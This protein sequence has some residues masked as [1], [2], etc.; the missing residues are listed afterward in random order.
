MS[1]ELVQKLGYQFRDTNHLKVALTHRSRG[2]EHN[3]RLEF[4]GDAVV[5][6]VIAEILY[7]Q[8]PK[9][10]EGDLSR[11]RATLVNRDALA[12]VARQFELGKYIFLGPGETRSGGSERQS[13]LSCA[14][15]AVIGAVYMD[16][17]FD[18]VRDRII[19]WYKDMLKSLS[20][21]SSHKDPKTQLQEFLQSQKLPLPVYAV[22]AIEGQAH[23]QQF[24]VCCQ[25]DGVVTKTYGKGTSRRRAEQDAA[26][27]ML[28][29]LKK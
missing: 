27:A 23:Q 16:G 15:E 9:A 3:E 29:E 22:T 26:M 18:A 14:M 28:G 11:W 17:G 2:G 12:D 13:I 10:S 25:I 6:F 4:L 21:A 7:Q 20:S 19:V 5:N 1:D 8:F 24:T